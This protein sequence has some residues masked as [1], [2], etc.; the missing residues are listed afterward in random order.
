MKDSPKKKRATKAKKATKKKVAKKA[1]KPA[2]TGKIS[3][4]QRRFA[5]GVVEGKTQQQAYL[6][7]GYKCS[8][9]AARM[10]ASRLITNDNVKELIQQ[11]RRQQARKA[12][13]T[14]ER[15]RIILAEIA[16]DPTKPSS[17]RIRAIGEDSRMAGHYEP[18]RVEVDAGPNVLQTIKERAA[19]VVSAMTQAYDQERQ[20]A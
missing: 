17:A 12:V 5:L 14:K 18:D 8:Q 16:E 19:N 3:D 13:L 2:T 20:K 10:N 4:R 9:D 7:A 11:L 6:D 15:K 1:A